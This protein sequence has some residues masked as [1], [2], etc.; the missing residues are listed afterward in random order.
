MIRVV[1]YEDYERME[2][3][4]EDPGEPYSAGG[5]C[6]CCF[7]FDT[8]REATEFAGIVIK[9]GGFA[10]MSMR[11]DSCEKKEKP[12]MTEEGK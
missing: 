6:G 7:F 2:M 1:A 9:H 4:F 8:W 3:D 12:A 10:V 11:N 5:L